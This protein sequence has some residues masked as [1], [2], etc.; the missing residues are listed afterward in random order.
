MRTKLLANRYAQA[1]FGLAAELNVLEE[2]DKDMKLIGKVLQENR[3]LR[4][5]MANPVIDW[6]KKD[7][8]LTALFSGKINVLTEK[9]F[10]LITRK[11]REEYMLDVCESYDVIYKDYKNI[12]PLKLTTAYKL[13]NKTRVLILK[14]LD[15]VSD[16]TL[17]IT[18][19]VDED[20]IGGLKLEFEDY[21]YDDSIK[22]QLKRL[23]N[24]FTDNLYV[25]KI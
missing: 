16:K 10:R 3:P 9:F 14:K 15:E 1:L 4:K 24:E 5:V 20:L 18:E 22:M 2:V 6:Y 23:G 11:G 7:K 25:S 21:Q 17:E 8:V 19:A 12:M 13:D